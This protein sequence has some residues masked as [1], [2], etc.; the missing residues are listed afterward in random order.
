M[1]AVLLGCRRECWVSGSA[2]GLVL[3]P[4]LSTALSGAQGPRAGSRRGGGG[5]RHWLSLE[6]EKQ[7]LLSLKLTWI[8]LECAV[9]KTLFC[10]AD[11]TQTECTVYY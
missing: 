5:F 7:H 11:L 9:K 2:L 4:I 6:G 3:V 1:G 10:L 8:P